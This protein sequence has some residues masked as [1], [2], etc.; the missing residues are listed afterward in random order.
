MPKESGG[1]QD[2]GV[3]GF[4][5]R[6]YLNLPQNLLWESFSLSSWKPTYFIPGTFPQIL[7][8]RVEKDNDS[9]DLLTNQTQSTRYKCFSQRAANKTFWINAVTVVNGIFAFFAF[10]EIVWILSRAKK[11]RTFYGQSTVLY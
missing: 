11:G 3:L 4:S 9:G 8:C 6:I 5:S 7:P 2:E 10:V 1:I